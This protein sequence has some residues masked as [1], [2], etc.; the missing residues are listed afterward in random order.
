MSN[1]QPTGETVKIGQAVKV[2]DEYG[3]L[4]DGL[5]TNVWG[6]GPHTCANV[7]FMSPNEDKNDSY[8]RQPE[9]LA[10]CSH[11]DS[12]SAHGRYWY[13]TGDRKPNTPPEC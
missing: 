9:R 3:R 4:H 7:L 10:S 12:G 2:V 13:V 5:V 11:R 6:N 1:T 8:G